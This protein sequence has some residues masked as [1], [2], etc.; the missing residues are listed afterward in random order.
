MFHSQPWHLAA[1]FVLMPI[2]VLIA[3]NLGLGANGL[4]VSIL[5]VAALVAVGGI[6]LKRLKAAFRSRSEA[7]AFLLTGN[8]EVT[9]PLEGETQIDEEDAAYGDGPPEAPYALPLPAPPVSAPRRLPEQLAI[10]SLSDPRAYEDRLNLAPGLRPHADEVLSGRISIFGVS[11]SGKS[12]TLAILCEEMARLGVPLLLAD[13]EDEYSALC[14]PD[15]FPR[16]YLA[17]SVDA[18]KR[19]DIPRYL[20]VD[21]QGAATF[22]RVVIEQGLQVIL[23]LNSYATDEEAARVM[24]GIIKGMRDWE[25]ERMS[26]D[27]VSCMFILEEASVWLPQNARESLLSR[28]CLAELQ[29]AL[30]ATVVRRGR[31]R[32]I[33]FTFATQRIAEID[34]RAMSSSWTILHRQTQDVD[35]KRYEE[36]GV[37]PEQAMALADGEAFVFSPQISNRRSQFRLRRS[38]HGAKTP[39]LASVLRHRRTLRSVPV[40]LDAYAFATSA[41]CQQRDMPT[42]NGT[43]A[44]PIQEEQQ[45]VP[46]VSELEKAVQA[47]KSGANSVRKLQTA[48]GDITYYRANELYR[49]MRQRRLID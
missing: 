10:H 3:T 42:S 28:E 17:G 44:L 48:L 40:Q 4:F 30:F 46:P 14:H 39:G 12:N 11:G 37:D 32:G 26:D 23:N 45:S 19:A 25:E 8:V 15:F 35:L 49:Q 27:R 34:K 31:K 47:W 9:S 1:F 33:G 38:P 21:E 29:Q 7:F 18:L 41:T 13:T 20:A 16:G 6:M 43:M 24:I 2:A 36:L 5:A 22:G